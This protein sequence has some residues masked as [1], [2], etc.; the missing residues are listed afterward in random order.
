MNY[1]ETLEYIHSVKWLGVKP[2][3][4]RTRQLLAALGNPEKSLK[5][6]HIAG[7]NGKGSTGACI[8][9]VFQKA[10]YR[11][12]FYISPYITRFNERMQADGVYISDDELIR[13]TEEIRPFAD[14]MA[15]PP[16]EFE[17]ITAL[18]M[19]FFLQKNCDIVVLETGMGGELDSTNVIGAPEAAVI[20]ALGFDH[21]SELGP[22]LADIAK[23]KAGIIKQGCD[24]VF[25]GGDDEADS[26]VSRVCDELGA[27][28]R[29]ADFSRIKNER[30]GLDGARFIFEPYGE[31]TLPLAGTYQTKNAAVA[32][33]A[34]E[35]LIEKGYKISGSDIKEG[36]AG[37]R[38]PGR[39]EILGRDPVFIL[40]GTH[41]A[42]GVEATVES[43]RRHFGDR[44]IVFIIGV[45]ADKD[46]D[47]MI[48]HI[49][50]LAKAF[51][52]VR[53][54]HPRAMEA[55]TLADRLSCCKKPTTACE[56][57]NAGVTKAI[58]YAGKDGIIC[59]LG[60]LYFSADIRAAYLQEKTP[61]DS[62]KVLL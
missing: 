6:V 56:P 62:D 1:T 15:D 37:V 31:L 36:L 30:F 55:K 51:F 33:T 40:D 14:A 18:A 4:E 60:S 2:G 26:V 47:S 27:R 24:V 22:R 23:A 58:E 10:G 5:F 61:L 54:D 44:E 53:P 9:S 17:L 57:L 3:L 21:V 11:T 45:M 41:N 28:L 50:P 16:T 8:T 12:G 25:Y 34:L 52:T 48:G 38:W 19:K 7:T 29:R 43:L 46:V 59:A 39:F 32:V 13:I 49:A 35:A 20:T 42:Q